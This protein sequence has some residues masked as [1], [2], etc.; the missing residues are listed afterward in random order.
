MMLSQSLQYE[1]NDSGNDYGIE[2]ALYNFS[3]FHCRQSYLLPCVV[4]VTRPDRF[5]N[6]S[7]APNSCWCRE[8]DIFATFGIAPDN[9][10]MLMTNSSTCESTPVLFHPLYAVLSEETDA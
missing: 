5:T 6:L 9:Q 10:R 8:S 3:Y 4:H 1:H 2:V 7:L